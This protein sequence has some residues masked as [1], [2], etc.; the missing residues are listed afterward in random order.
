MMPLWVL[1]GDF[2]NDLKIQ[3]TRVF[4]TTFAIMWGTMSIVMMMAFGRGFKFRIEASMLNA[5]NQIIRLYGGQTSKKYQGLSEG[6]L[7]RFTKEDANVLLESIPQIQE[8]CPSYG[9]WGIR[10]KNGSRTASTYLEAVYPNF[11][12]LRTMY[13]KRG[14]R[15]LNE[16]DIIENRRVLFLGSVITEELFGDEDPIGRTIELDGVPFT[17]VGVMQKKMQMGMSNGPDD[18]RAIIPFTTFESLYEHRTLRMITIRPNK[19]TD[20]ERIR[21]DIYRV[22]GRKHRFD[23]TDKNALSMWDFVENIREMGKIF[24]GIQIFLGVVG[25]LTLLVAGVGVANIMYVV[26]KERTREIGIKKAVGA[27]SCHITAQFVFESVLIAVIGGGLGIFVSWA[28][29][30]LFSMIPVQNQGLAYLGKPQISQAVLFTTSF[31]L[32]MIGV[33]AGVF[34][35]QRAAKLDP[36]ESLRYE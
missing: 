32:G 11:E 17:L 24:T 6:R 29:I 4:L 10:L 20:T 13:P 23:P 18:R 34:P 27:R 21:S 15:F 5:G 7:I 35:A 2:L 16:R 9:R 36:V 22:L 12:S 8:V 31:I 1:I 25:G 26:V 33:V 19:L 3:K 28:L 30:T 14:G